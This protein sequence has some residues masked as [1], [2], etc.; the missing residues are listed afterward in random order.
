MSQFG[1]GGVTH[2]AVGGN[3]VYRGTIFFSGMERHG[4]V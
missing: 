1:Y 4:V 3:N 2:G